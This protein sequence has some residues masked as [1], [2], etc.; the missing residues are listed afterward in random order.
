[1]RKRQSAHAR[2]AARQFGKVDRRAT[3]LGPGING[4]T[5]PFCCSKIPVKSRARPQMHAFGTTGE[6][7]LEVAFAAGDHDDARS[8][9]PPPRRRL[10][11]QP[12]AS[13][14]TPC[15]RS[16]AASGS[17]PWL[18]CGRRFGRRPA[19][20]SR[21]PADRSRASS[22][23]GVRAP[24]GRIHPTQ[25]AVVTPSRKFQVRFP[26]PKGASS[27]AFSAPYMRMGLQGDANGDQGGN[28]Q[29]QGVH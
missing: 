27:L 6:P 17:S 11:R 25:Q 16:A 8:L 1:M 3:L 9:C 22:H 15:L 18:R 23:R 7:L 19:R 10:P 13:E 20:S 4:F 5:Q 14:R 21:Q 2:T 12:A 28:H 29:G 24:S 26:L